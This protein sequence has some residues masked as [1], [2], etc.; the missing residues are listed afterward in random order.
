MSFECISFKILTFICICDRLWEPSQS[1]LFLM[2]MFMCFINLYHV[3]NI[4]CKGHHSISNIL[5]VNITFWNVGLLTLGK[6]WFLYI[7]EVRIWNYI[8][9]LLIL[10]TLRAILRHF[11]TYFCTLGWI[12]CIRRG[13]L[14]SFPFPLFLRILPGDFSRVF[15]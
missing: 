10:M 1:H 12:K 5:W 9:I 13:Y 8:G 2:S 11:R 15:P 4:L 7:F 6:K 14:L 3:Q